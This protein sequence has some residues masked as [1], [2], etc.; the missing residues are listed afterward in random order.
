MR[1]KSTS[2]VPL[3]AAARALS[4]RPHLTL[5]IAP[6]PPSGQ[7]ASAE[8]VVIGGVGAGQNHRLLRG[9]ADLAA[10][11]LRYHKPA[12]HTTLRPASSR[13]AAVFDVL[14]RTR[15]ELLGARRWQGVSANLETRLDQFYQSQ[16]FAALP[17]EADPPVA[18]LLAL[19]LRARVLAAP[20]PPAIAHLLAYW[21]PRLET[22]A[23]RLLDA[24]PAQLS[25]QQRYGELVRDII[26][27]LETAEEQQSREHEQGSGDAASHEGETQEADTPEDAPDGPQQ[28]PGAM[29]EPMPQESSMAAVQ[30]DELPPEDATEIP[31]ET[32]PSR[33]Q[34]NTPDFSGLTHTATY[35]PFTTRFDEIIDADRLAS[36]E[37]IT[38]LRAL[39]DQKLIHLQSI[40]SKL[41]SRLQRA[42][43]AQQSVAWE[44]GMDEGVIDGKRIARRIADPTFEHFYKRPKQ[45]EFRSTVVS[46]L[47]DNSGSMRGR[48]I[49]IAAICA[50]ILARTL[51]RCG[52]KVEILGFTTRDWKGGQSH[53]AWIEQH[54]P[55]HPGRL[56]DLRH[57]VYKSADSRWQKARRNLGLMLKDGLLKEN[58]DGE[59]VLWAHQRLLSRGEQR[60]ILMVISDGA[61]VDDSTLSANGSNYLDLHLREVIR[62]IETYS[63]VE[64]LA[65]GIG[66][67]VTRYYQRAVTISDVEQLGD[68]MAR[69]LVK[70][71]K[72]K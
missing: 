38:R 61:P 65:I 62:T 21:Q 32:S 58:I 53:K 23:G 66:H 3:E 72:G 29:Q 70:L 48:P 55:P 24:L 2:P 27:T 35:A 19:M 39:L 41:S 45:T 42:L 25:H 44:Y 54:R 4:R 14:E 71:L 47:L 33:E 13:A 63:P 11:S 36:P 43:L 46:L 1:Q 22:L 52:V 20:P 49:T 31:D 10:L 57:I 9:E 56:N 67:D 64:L 60:R 37:D 51:E 6:E 69:E 68:V 17:R 15:V 59:A 12:L 26:H 40:A 16:G 18:E 5:R 7:L 34:R 28:A 8:E 50:D 30:S